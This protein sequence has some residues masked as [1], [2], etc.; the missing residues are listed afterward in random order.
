MDYGGPPFGFG[1]AVAASLGSPLCSGSR[2]W[3]GSR[4]EQP[5]SDG[6]MPVGLVGE[7]LQHQL[8]HPGGVGLALHRLHDLRRSAHPLPAPCRRGPCRRRQGWRRSLLRRPPPAHRRRGRAQPPR[9]G[10]LRR[11]YPHRRARPRDL[12]GQRVV[13]P[14]RRAPARR[15]RRRLPGST[16]T[17]TSSRPS[18]FARRASSPDHHLRA[19]A[20]VAPAATVASIELDAPGVDDVAHLEVGEAPV[21]L[22]AAPALRPVARAGSPRSARPAAGVGREG[23]EVGLGEVAVVLGIGLHPPGR[24][25]AGVLVPVPGLLQRPCRPLESTAAWR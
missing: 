2:K 9:V 23:H 3:L 8:A 22:Q 11:A 17:S 1:V 19:A 14:A 7:P 20:G 18:A 24:R 12:A 16:P 15:A 25:H 21:V 6:R 13:E 5:G 4:C 10:D